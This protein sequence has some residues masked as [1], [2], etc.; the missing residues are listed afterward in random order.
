MK[1]LL[2]KQRA[3][4]ARFTRSYALSSKCFV[5]FVVYSFSLIIRFKGKDFFGTEQVDVAE[6]VYK[7]V[8]WHKKLQALA[9]ELSKTEVANQCNNQQ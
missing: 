5:L 3:A 6:I 9:K 2:C 4:I 7:L 1:G 8:D